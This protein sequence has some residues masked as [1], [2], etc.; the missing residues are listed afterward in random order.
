MFHKSAFWVMTLLGS[1]TLS[2]IG[3]LLTPTIRRLLSRFSSVYKIKADKQRERYEI[4]LDF[5]REDNGRIYILK[6]DVLHQL[7]WSIMIQSFALTA[8]LAVDGWVGKLIAVILTII[9]F[10]FLSDTIG[11]F[12]KVRGAESAIFEELQ[13]KLSEHEEERKK[14]EPRF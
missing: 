1:I 11:L 13:A 3:N 7:L 2:I 4:I 8:L 10:K 9:N 5:L 12:S 6:M 14:G